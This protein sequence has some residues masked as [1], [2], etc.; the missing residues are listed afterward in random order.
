[1]EDH[2]GDTVQ[3][4]FRL[5]P[6]LTKTMVAAG[7]LDMRGREKKQFVLARLQKQV[8]TESPQM[9]VAADKLAGPLIDLGV[10]INK[11]KY[12]LQKTKTVEEGEPV[13]STAQAR[14]AATLRVAEEAEKWFSGK[15]ITAAS[16]VLGIASLME[17][18]EDL[19]TG[20]GS[21][22]TDIVLTAVREIVHRVDSDISEE[23][24]EAV[25]L[26]IDTFGE[27]IVGFGVDIMTGN[28]DFSGLVKTIKE[29]CCWCCAPPGAVTEADPQSL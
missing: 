13:I 19:F 2:A 6:F 28:Y 3:N 25:L 22:K 11:G 29:A 14:D 27:E 7:K 21:V 16:V 8:E 15:T 12:R 5:T 1:M 4:S 18:V 20:D 10:A 24:R 9:R 23:D 26:A 17:V